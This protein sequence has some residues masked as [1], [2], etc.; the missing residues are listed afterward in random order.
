MF[1]FF[2]RAKRSTLGVDYPDCKNFAMLCRTYSVYRM[3]YGNQ[4]RSEVKLY[5][6]STP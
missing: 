4:L 5:E 2:E 3:G 1:P 6:Q